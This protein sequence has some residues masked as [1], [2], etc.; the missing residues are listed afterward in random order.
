[1]D[2]VLSRILLVSLPALPAAGALLVGLLP[3]RSTR[4]ARAVGWVFSLAALSVWMALWLG[5]RDAAE[6]LSLRIAWVP[7]LG[8]SFHL[9]LDSA[10]LWMSGLVAAVGAAA[11]VGT[12]PELPDL[13]RSHLVCLLLAECGMLGAVV[14]WD[15]ILFIAC[16]EIMLIPFFF[17]MGR[18]PEHRGV[19]AATRFFV[20][21]IASSVVL[22]VGV[23]RL[24]HLAGEPRTFDLMEIARRLDPAAAA[25][26]AWFFV[27]AFLMRLAAVPLHTWFPL[28]QAESPVAA[29][30][31]LAG[32]VLPLGGYGVYHLLRRIFGADLGGTAETLAWIGLGTAL[33]GGLVALVQRDLKRLLAGLCMAQT[34]LSLLGLS[35]GTPESVRGGLLLLA[36]AGLAGAAS[37]LFAGVVCGARDSQ[38]IADIAG[39]W[40]RQPLFC[41]LFLAAMA[42]LGMLPGTAGFA[43]AWPILSAMRTDGVMLSLAALALL[44]LGGAGLWTYRR[45][46]G[47]GFQADLWST[48]RWPRRRQVV[49][50]LLLGVI[51]LTLGLWVGAP[52]P[53]SAFGSG[54]MP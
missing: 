27:P 39:L 13:N 54:G 14:S 26:V 17:L 45:L 44:A 33:L 42:S 25:G 28:A 23:L 21:S 31:M 30:V 7:D 41:G 3:A 46:S 53:A 22:W 9:A 52:S 36:S 38:R 10:G 48:A 1:M 29:S 12:L 8:I 15:L 19:A 43:G 24:V 50:L 49:T 4:L 16:W 47:G 11:M 34:G 2:G 18:G 6:P 5:M 37:F 51:I 20:T 40:R 32:G 35:L